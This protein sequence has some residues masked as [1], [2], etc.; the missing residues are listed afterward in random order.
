MINKKNIIIS[1]IIFLGIILLSNIC[2]A[3]DLDVINDYSITVDP[4]KDGTLDITYHIEWEVLDSTSEGPLTWVKIGIPNSKADSIRALSNNIKSIRYYNDNGDYIRIDFT[5]EYHAGD[6]AE[7]DFTLHQSYMYTLNGNRCTY[8][9]TPGWF[10]SL[11]VKN[12]SVYWNAENVLSSSSEEKNSDNYLVWNDSLRK[13]GK[14]KTEVIYDIDT[15]NVD[16]NKQYKEVTSTTRNSSSVSSMSGI[17][18]LLYFFIIASIVLSVLSAF[19]GTGY[20]SHGGY[21]YSSYGHR[22]YDRSIRSSR[23][24]SSCACVSSCACAC[25][26]AGGG[27]A[28][29]SKK[30][31][32]GTNLTTKNIE[33]VLKKDKKR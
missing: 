17:M 1:F 5:K 19:T 31:L 16:S 6:I 13:G 30:D 32:Y 4:R 21:G 8:N 2:M 3:A 25:A 27:R 24:R 14:L 22:S 18:S 10:G 7:F 12:I 26:C 28:G 33:K 9:F 29:C 23:S 11:K 20:R 15:F